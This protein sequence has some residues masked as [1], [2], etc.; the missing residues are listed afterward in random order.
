MPVAFSCPE[1]DKSL[2]VKDE[3]AGKKVKCP[4]CGEPIVVEAADDPEPESAVQEPPRRKGRDDDDDDRPRKKKKKKKKSNT[5]LWIALGGGAALLLLLVVAG[6]VLL[7][8]F[9]Q[10]AAAT[11]TTEQAKKKQDQR[12]KFEPQVE[13]KRPKG[14]IPRAM[15][16][17]EVKNAMKQIGLAYHN[18][19]STSGKAPMKMQDLMQ[20]LER[21]ALIETMLTDGS[22]EFAYGVKPQDMTQGSSN[23]LIAWEKDADNL[24]RRVVLYGDGSVDVLTEDDFQSKPK[25]QSRK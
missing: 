13:N 17:Q 19:V 8:V 24:G 11:K 7:I 25:A 12:P 22:V 20:H 10:P 21:N 6:V 15:D 2:K 5:L 1:C 4:G 9:N 18:Y 14:G 16:V 23:T 3:L